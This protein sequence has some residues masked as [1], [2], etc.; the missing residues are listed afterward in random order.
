MV[1]YW[2]VTCSHVEV[3]AEDAETQ[4]EAVREASKRIHED[5]EFYMTEA[6]EQEEKE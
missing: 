5:P 3:S 2:C 1:K 4:D 6:F